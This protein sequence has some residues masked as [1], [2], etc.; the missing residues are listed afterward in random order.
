MRRIGF[1]DFPDAWDGPFA[2]EFR[3]VSEH[4][5]TVRFRAEMQKHRFDLYLPRFMLPSPG[6]VPQSLVAVFDA[7]RF[8]RP[9]GF[10]TGHIDPETTPERCVY[11][12][13]EEM[14]H[15]FRFDTVVEGQRYALYVPKEVFG[16]RRRP[17]RIAL[18]L[19]I[20]N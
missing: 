18:E 16:A 17:E 15:S 5:K 20:N 4:T 19:D 3:F 2:V 10:G 12:F 11:S 14:G 13:S 8:D 7:S 9:V 6:G 1:L